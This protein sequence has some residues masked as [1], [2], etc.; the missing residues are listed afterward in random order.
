[1]KRSYTCTI[2]LGAAVAIGGCASP[3]TTDETDAASMSLTASEADK[4]GTQ[5][6]EGE[7]GI[8][9]EQRER[10][11]DEFADEFPGRFAE[12]LAD[13]L[14]EEISDAVGDRMRSERTAREHERQPRRGAPGVGEEQPIGEAGQLGESGQLGEPGQVGVPGQGVPGQIGVPGQ[15][16]QVGGPQADEGPTGAAQQPFI[17]GYGYPAFYGGLG[18]GGLGYGGLGYGGLG[19]GGLGMGGLG[20]G[21]FFW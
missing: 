3:T 5:Q 6:S 15:G 21:G 19:W 14:A 10:M 9:P 13:D 11:A 4:Q 8:T 17:Y 7:F 2:A 18:Y 16:G 12:E 1:M 20:M